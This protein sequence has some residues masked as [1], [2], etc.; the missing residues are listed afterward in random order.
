MIPASGSIARATA[1]RLASL[2]HP[3]GPAPLLPAPPSAARLPS[4]A[5]F[6]ALATAAR[7]ACAT[8]RSDSAPPDTADGASGSGSGARCHDGNIPHSEISMGTDGRPDASV[9]T[10]SSAYL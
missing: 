7:C 1:C 4:S 10:E 3:A 6:T 5:A 9:G 8:A 2:A